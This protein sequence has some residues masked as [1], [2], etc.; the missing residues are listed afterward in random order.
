MWRPE[1]DELISLA[2]KIDRMLMAGI[3]TSLRDLARRW[4]AL[5]AEIKTSHK[6]ID[7]LV[8]AAA[9]AV[10]KRHGVEVEIAGRFPVKVDD[11]ADPRRSGLR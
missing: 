11:N 10:M 1:T 7:V 6:Q 3:K 2:D 8:R 9:P 5:D 4:R